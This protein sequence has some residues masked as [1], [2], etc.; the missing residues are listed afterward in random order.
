[1]P[2]SRLWFALPPESG[3]PPGAALLELARRP[4]AALLHASAGGSLELGARLVALGAPAA[5]IVERPTPA[6]LDHLASEYPDLELAVVADA[7]LLREAIAR[8]LGL[9]TPAAARI[10]PRPGSLHAF[11]WPTGQDLDARHE[12]I[13]LDLDWFPPWHSGQPRPKFPGG[14]GVAGASRR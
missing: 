10:L 4:L 12:L 8:A 14:P 7:E 5:R 1:M 2:L 9:P 13:G 3:S 6:D 11:H